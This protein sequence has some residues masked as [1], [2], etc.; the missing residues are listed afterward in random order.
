MDVAGTALPA[1][2]PW[3]ERREI[4]IPAAQHAIAGQAL[5]V[6]QADIV[7]GAALDTK[8]RL[9]TGKSVKAV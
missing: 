2:Q 7:A 3:A 6:E 4:G 5:G 1:N 9:M 8:A